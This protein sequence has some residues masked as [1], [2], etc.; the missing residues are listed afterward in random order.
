MSHRRSASTGPGSQV[1]TF[2]LEPPLATT[3]IHAA[4]LPTSRKVIAMGNL[5]LAT[6]ADFSLTDTGT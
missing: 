2:N 4:V 5:S 6:F 3:K 1:I